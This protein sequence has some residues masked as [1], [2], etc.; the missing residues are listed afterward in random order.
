MALV[1]EYRGWDKET[2]MLGRWQEHRDLF[3]HIPSQSRF[4]RRR[5]NLRLAFN[6]IRQVVPSWM[7]MAQDRYALRCG[8]APA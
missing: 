8:C 7:N 1:G 5:R 6:L 4:N 3:P 2:K